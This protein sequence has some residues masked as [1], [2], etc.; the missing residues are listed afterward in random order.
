[1]F[2]AR[3]LEQELNEAKLKAADRNEWQEV[4]MKVSAE[5]DQLRKV[6]DEFARQSPG[7]DKWLM[8]DYRDLPHVIAKNT[9]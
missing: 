6:V 1:M 2:H 3:Q 9:K 5:R 4:A 7:D 8:A